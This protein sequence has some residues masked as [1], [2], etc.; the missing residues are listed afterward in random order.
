MRMSKVP[1]VARHYLKIGIA[2]FLIGPT[3]VGKS[4]VPRAMCE[5]DGR[6]LVEFHLSYRSPTDIKGFPVPDRERHVMSWLPDERMRVD[7]PANFFL[8][9]LPQ[10]PATTQA[11]CYE[12][13][14]EK[15]IESWEMDQ[16]P[17]TDGLP[18][19]II[20]CAGNPPGGGEFVHQMPPALRSRVA[21]ISVEPDLSDW[22]QWA[23]GAGIDNLVIG[24]LKFKARYGSGIE[25][26]PKEGGYGLLHWYDPS[27]HPLSF[28]TP[29]GW[30][31]VSDL[32][33]HAPALRD[34]GEA[35]G[36]IV[37]IPVGEQFVAYAKVAAKIPNADAVIKGDL[38]IAPPGNESAVY[39]FCGAL[40]GAVVRLPL[41]DRVNGFRV[42]CEYCMRWWGA[43]DG[44]AEF[45]ALTM[46]DLCRTKAFRE[47]YMQLLSGN[48]GRTFPEWTAF[49]KRFGK[50]L[51]LSKE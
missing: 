49:T 51:G 44:K 35:I 10:S 45:A 4:S 48:D 2:P 17:W 30:H 12:W 19:Q 46:A 37:S 36:G 32:I 11:A 38:L 25:S 43:E 5:E 33:K 26:G 3:G 6:R 31:R 1:S 42:L 18:I 27:I 16:R 9:E 7:G 40:A 20:M 23:M 21:F 22:C 50:M 39:A 13:L 24:F 47:I 15:R 28:P 29:R 41:Q 34:D 14:L 8:D